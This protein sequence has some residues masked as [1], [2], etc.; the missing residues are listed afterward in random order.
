MSSTA[1]LKVTLVRS[2]IS[3]PPKHRECVKALGLRRMQ[4]SVVVKDNQTTRGLINKIYYLLNVEA[5]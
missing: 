4:H 2:I 1:E 5:V 3:T